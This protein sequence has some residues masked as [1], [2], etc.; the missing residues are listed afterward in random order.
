MRTWLWAD[1]NAIIINNNK[2]EF[3]AAKRKKFPNIEC[4]SRSCRQRS[5]SGLCNNFMLSYVLIKKRKAGSIE[6]RCTRGYVC[7]YALWRLS[8]SPPNTPEVEWTLCAT[9]KNKKFTTFISRTLRCAFIILDSLFF[10]A[11]YIHGENK[12][13]CC[14]WRVA[15]K[16]EF[17]RGEI[18]SLLLFLM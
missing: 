14:C 3:L 9:F 13:K 18:F 1:S 10:S 5:S 7:T 11:K 17:S 8:L 15:E 4:I 2:C 16:M 12:I 6:M